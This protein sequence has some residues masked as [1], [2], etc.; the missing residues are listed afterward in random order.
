MILLDPTITMNSKS[1]N[2]KIGSTDGNDDWQ[3]SGD[4]KKGSD[5]VV[6][7]AIPIVM[8]LALKT[9]DHARPV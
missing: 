8:L 6:A 1:G 7:I 9:S 3:K 2:K 4:R 5:L